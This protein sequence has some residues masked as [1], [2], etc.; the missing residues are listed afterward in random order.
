MKNA[1]W[2]PRQL[3]RPHALSK[4][5]GCFTFNSIYSVDLAAL[6]EKSKRLTLELAGDPGELRRGLRQSMAARTANEGH[7]RGA[8]RMS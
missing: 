4:R 8:P 2:A 5:V 1:P 3:Q 6:L 7:P